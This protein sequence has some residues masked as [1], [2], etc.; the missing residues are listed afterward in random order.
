MPVE[1]AIEHNVEGRLIPM[2][3][4]ESLAG[5]VLQLLA[6]PDSRAR[7]GVAARQRSLLYDQRLTLAAMTSLIETQGSSEG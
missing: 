6:N 3:Q 4:P 7:F 1:E 2:D 5:E